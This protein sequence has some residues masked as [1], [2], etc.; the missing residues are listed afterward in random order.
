MFHPVEAVDLRRITV[1][2]AT[3]TQ[4]AKAE[5]HGQPLEITANRFLF[6]SFAWK[7]QSTSRQP[8]DALMLPTSLGALTLCDI[9]RAAHHPKLFCCFDLSFPFLYRQ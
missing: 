8:L 5:G 9:E 2:K 4:E 1:L 6:D 7:V 3:G